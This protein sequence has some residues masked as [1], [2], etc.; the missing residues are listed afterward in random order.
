MA[1]AQ[2]ALDRVDPSRIEQSVPLET[3]ARRPAPKID[4]PAAVVIS[5][6]ARVGIRVGGVQIE[7]LSELRPADFAD[8][9]EPY[10]GRPLS[11]NDLQAL[12]S[13]VADRA[14]SKGYP[15]ATAS[16]PKQTMQAGILRLLVDEGRIDE[17]RLA[18]QDNAAVKA[19][20]SPLADGQPVRLAELERRLLLAGDVD[21]VSVRRTRL[22]R[23]GA[24]QV[25]VVETRSDRV[26]GTVALANDGSR[27]IGPEQAELRLRVSQLFTSSDTLNLTGLMTPFEPGELGF[28]AIR[29]AARVHPSGTELFATGSWS[30]TRP[31]AYLDAFNLS[32]RSWTA[33]AGLSQPILRQRAASVW[34]EGG[35]T[36]RRSRQER[37]DVR[38][39]EDRLTL[40]RIGLFGTM[41]ALSGRLRTGAT[42]TQ[43]LDALDATERGD[44][45]ASRRDADGRFTSVFLWSD[46]TGPVVGKVTARVA[47]ASQIASGPLLATEELGLGGAAFLRGY[48]YSERSGDRGAMVAAEL[49]HQ[50]GWKLGPIGAPELY[51]FA[52]AGRVTNVRGGFG[53]GDLASAGAGLRTQLFKKVYADVAL[54]VPLTGPRYDTGD[55][56]PSVLFRLSRTF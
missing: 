23:E 47:V 49:R 45:L 21:G 25:L 16:V 37:E 28:A 33:G 26:S 10:L 32:G 42:L 8:L 38:I 35:L 46:W 12:A 17:V 2:T 52:D 14:R 9:F 40:G 54:A 15:F 34:I 3:E 20:L 36:V 44:P 18:G 50:T 29:Y 39:R 1:A 7:G 53:S 51:V 22:V 30:R 48:D 19:A 4:A 43:G 6:A 41:S 24:R 27:P 55:K 13:A 11:P 56:S 31:G 5:G